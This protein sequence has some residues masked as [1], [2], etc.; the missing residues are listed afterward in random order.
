MRGSWNPVGL[1]T[2]LLSIAQIITGGWMGFS[3]SR[4]KGV[5]FPLEKEGNDPRLP[6]SS[7]SQESKWRGEVVWMVWPE[8]FASSF[9]NLRLGETNMGTD[10][11]IHNFLLCLRS[12][13]WWYPVGWTSTSIFACNHLLYNVVISVV[14]V[15]LIWLTFSVNSYLNP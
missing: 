10:S 9:F 8:G 7:F 6:F 3:L 12:W 11:F 15:S 13:L 14:A 1:P 5:W 2:L 4:R